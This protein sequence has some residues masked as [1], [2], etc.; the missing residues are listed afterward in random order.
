MEKALKFAII[1]IIG[2]LCFTTLVYINFQLFNLTDP[3]NSGDNGTADDVTSDES[4]SDQDE[5][6]NDQTDENSGNQ[7]DTDNESEEEEE[8]INTLIVNLSL[9]ID[10]NNGSMKKIINFTM[11]EN[12]TAFEA[13]EKY[14]QVD[15]DSKY[16]WGAFVTTIDY[17]EENTSEGKYWL[18]FING[19]FAPVSA[20]AYELSHNDKIE[21]KYGEKYN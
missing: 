7:D 3:N 15:C 19:D 12:S 18:Y 17:L 16:E 5:Q 21:W 11:P 8:E 6:S 14:C 4:K 10:Y 1:G 2:I 9:Y 20:G 13:T